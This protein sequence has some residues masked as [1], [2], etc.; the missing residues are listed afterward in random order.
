MS[1]KH[2]TAQGLF[3]DDVVDEI[4]EADPSDREN[5]TTSEQSP[6]GVAGVYRITCTATGKFYI[7]SAVD[8]QKR[9]NG[10]RC[11]LNKGYEK[12]DKDPLEIPTK[13]CH[14][15]LH[16]Q[17]AYNK[18]GPGAFTWEIVETVEPP[19]D[20]EDLQAWAERVLLPREQFH[21]DLHWAGGCMFNMLPIAGSVLGAK[22]SLETRARIS[23]AASNPPPETRTKMSEAARRRLPELQARMAEVNRNLSPE[24]R[25]KMAEA[26]KGSSPSAETRAKI[27]AAGKGRIPTP[28]TRQK[29]SA[30]QSNRSPETRAKLSAARKGKRHTPETK[31]KLSEA[32]KNRSAETRAKISAAKKGH[33]KSPETCAK[34]SA[35]NRGKV[36]SPEHRTKLSEAAKN[37]SAEYRAK[38]SEAKKGKPLFPETRAKLVEAWKKRRLTSFSAET[39]AKMSASAK[40]RRQRQRDEQSDQ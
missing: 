10:H 16:L 35:A 1:R 14:N 30:A 8:I 32:A 38:M 24:A 5:A 13:D 23:E 6:A 37:R 11:T 18:Y 15:N 40:V 2:D 20:G 25:A 26:R 29:L 9:W 28:E 17:R 4:A 19:V 12:R 33:I 3:W 27:S 36:L 31:A 7:G 34:I 21:L 39:R 22:R